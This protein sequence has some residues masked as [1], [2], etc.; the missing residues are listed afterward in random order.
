MSRTSLFRWWKA[1]VV[2]LTL[3]LLA[4]TVVVRPIAEMRMA[5]FFAALVL[6]ATFLRIESG[7]TSV[8]FEAAVAFG[9]IVL[10]HGP[11]VALVAVFLGCAAQGFYLAIRDRRVQLDSLYN[12]SQLA[13]TYAIDGALY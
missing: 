6:V 13:L 4:A 1:G 8:G 10:F 7:D 11:A 9:A 5:L 12:P 3:G 2:V